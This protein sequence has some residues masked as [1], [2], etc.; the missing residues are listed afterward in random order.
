MTDMNRLEKLILALSEAKTNE[1]RE[2]AKLVVVTAA[3]KEQE[4]IWQT[5]NSGINAAK[6]ALDDYLLETTE[7]TAKSNLR[8]EEEARA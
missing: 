1:K 3:L 5:A 6:K 4:N 8:A 2:A 7:R